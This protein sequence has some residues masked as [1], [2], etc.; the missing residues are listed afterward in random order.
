MTIAHANARFSDFATPTYASNWFTLGHLSRPNGTT[1]ASS[2]VGRGW[3]DA[4][5]I[6]LSWLHRPSDLS[7]EGLDPPSPALLKQV[8]RVVGRLEHEGVLPGPAN[9]VPTADGGIV[10]SSNIGHGYFELAFEPDGAAELRVFI[11]NKLLN[12]HALGGGLV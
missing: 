9:T 11:G 1:G 2:S 3:A 4:E 6:L 8:L 5:D 12:R 7:D 10:F